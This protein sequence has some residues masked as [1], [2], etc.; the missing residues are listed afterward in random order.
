[1]NHPPDFTADLH[2]LTTEQGGR[3]TAAF[4]G[5]FPHVKFGFSSYICGGKQKFINKDIVKPGEDVTAEITLLSTI[6]FKNSLKAGFEFDVMEGSRI[7]GKGTII[8][9]L[10][11]ELVAE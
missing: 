6:P 3:K 1:M 9:I 11:Q 5:Y 4:N 2:Y 7:V 8:E 10:N